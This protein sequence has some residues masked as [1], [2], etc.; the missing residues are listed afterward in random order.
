MIRKYITRGGSCTLVQSITIFPTT[1]TARP[2][3]LDPKYAKALS[4]RGD[5]ERL[6][7][8]WPQAQ[9]DMDRAIEIDP[10][11]VLSGITRA[12][13][14]SVLHRPDPAIADLTAVI[15]AEPQ[16]WYAYNSRSVVNARRSKDEA[17]IADFDAALERA[18]AVRSV[19][20]CNRGYT[21]ALMGKDDL[22]KR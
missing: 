1:T 12:I 9:M 13:L 18:S 2:S 3:I 7:G 8:N 21:H 19:P 6:L 11:D 20:H 17:A 16:D 15:E 5:L 10:R 22:G 4:N 14:Y